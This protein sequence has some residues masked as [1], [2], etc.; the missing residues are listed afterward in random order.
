MGMGFAINPTAEK[1]MD[2]FL[3]AAKAQNGTEAG[4]G[5]S[6]MPAGAAAPPPPTATMPPPVQSSVVAMPAPSGSGGVV[7]GN[8]DAKGACSCYC[9]MGSFP[10]AAQ[11]I[12]GMGGYAGAVPMSGG[13]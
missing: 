5:M 13:M 8:V 4:M 7:A 2:K 1:S 10:N 12:G 11:G 9:G 6:T 3:A